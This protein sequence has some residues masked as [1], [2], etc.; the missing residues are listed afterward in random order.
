MY[1]NIWVCTHIFL[2]SR[3]VSLFISLQDLAQGLCSVEI[4]ILKLK[5]TYYLSISL[6]M[7][8][9]VAKAIARLDTLRSPKSAIAVIN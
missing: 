8:I 3:H 5:L 9:L 2:V 7:L 4:C 1:S 6:T